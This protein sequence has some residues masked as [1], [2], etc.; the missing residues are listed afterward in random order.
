MHALNSLP[1]HRDKKKVTVARLELLAAALR[2]TGLVVEME[3]KSGAKVPIIDVALQ[4]QP[5][6]L[7]MSMDISLG[8]TGGARAVPFIQAQLASMEPLR[9]LV[10]LLKALM[11]VRVT[12]Y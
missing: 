7:I 10:L 9:A 8:N 2:K 3:V 6:G 5:G 12:C 11:K 1:V 4:C